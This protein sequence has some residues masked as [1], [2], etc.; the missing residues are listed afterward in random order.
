MVK[1][2]NYSKA[3][4][5]VFKNDLVSRQSINFRDSKSLGLSGDV[6]YLDIQGSDEALEE[7][8]KLLKDVASE[9][10]GAEKEKVVDVIEKQEESANAG[11]GSIFG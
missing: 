5:I 2:E 9:V 1:K 3:G 8:R 7:A 10:T 4:D 6:Y 11:F